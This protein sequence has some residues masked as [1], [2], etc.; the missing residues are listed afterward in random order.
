MTSPRRAIYTV[1]QRLYQFNVHIPSGI[2][3]G[4][5]PVIVTMM[6]NHASGP[7]GCRQAPGSIELLNLPGS[8]FLS[9]TFKPSARGTQ[10]LGSSNR[11]LLCDMVI[12][13]YCRLHRVAALLYYS[14][15]GLCS[16]PAAL[17]RLGAFIGECIGQRLHHFFHA[18][19]DV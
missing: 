4:D 16:R 8:G 12:R 19:C 11:R 2:A 10:H 6:C 17:V 15:P 13:D 7:D 9:Q 18:I 3:D 14:F 5:A 1:H